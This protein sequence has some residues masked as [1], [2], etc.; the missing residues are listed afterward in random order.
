MSKGIEIILHAFAQ[1]GHCKHR[2]R[3]AV[4]HCR[5][6]L[7]TGVLRFVAMETGLLGHSG[8]V[9]CHGMDADRVCDISLTDRLSDYWTYRAYCRKQCEVIWHGDRK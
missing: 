6:R 1:A 9:S 8:Q 4:S 5:P 2:I 7:M 3:L